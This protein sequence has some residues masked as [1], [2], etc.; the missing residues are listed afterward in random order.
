[1]DIDGTLLNDDSL[2]SDENLYALNLAK[3]EGVK[4]V[5]ASGRIFQAVKS[6]KDKL[7]IG[8]PFIA[9]NGAW[10]KDLETGVDIF[11]NPIPL[12]LAQEV[13]E[14]AKE[15]KLHLN[16]YIN[17]NLYVFEKNRFSEYYYNA[18]GVKAEAVGDLGS[19]FKKR[20]K[21][22]TKM[23][24]ICKTSEEETNLDRKEVKK[25]YLFFKKY[26]K[27]RLFVTESQGKH[28]E[29]LNYGVSKGTA[30]KTVAKIL[31]IKEEEVVAVGDGI[32]DIELLKTAGLGLA[33]D[34]AAQELKNEADRVIGFSNNN[35]AI[36]EIINEFFTP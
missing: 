29:F 27:D 24:V 13:A 15:K 14:A 12:N 32:N 8:T 30:L 1:M 36:K 3:K 23:L 33:V 6:L 18:Y 7:G 17:D 31:E 10:I 4:I 16:I 20:K 25:H 26:F 21:P 5:Y 2:I 35:H 22:P 11:H 28:I 9:Y 19:F 34:N